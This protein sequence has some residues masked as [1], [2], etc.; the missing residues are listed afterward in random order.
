[1]T[2][3]R[4]IVLATTG[5]LGDLH[6]FLAIALGLKSRGHRVAVATCNYY[7]FR[8]ENLGLEFRPVAPHL[9][10][11]DPRVLELVTD[12][13]KGSENIFRE[14][15]MPWIKDSFADTGRA[16]EGADFVLSHPITLAVPLV[17]E[18]RNLPWASAVLAPISF[19]SK[20]EHLEF[21]GY[22]FVSWLSRTFPS[23]RPLL[24]KEGRRQSLAWVKPVV[25]L[26]EEVGLRTGSHPLFDGQHSPELVLALYSRLLGAPQ[27]DWPPSTTITGF[28]FHDRKDGRESLSPDLARFLESGPPPLVFTL[29]SSAVLA[30]G[31]F[32]AES[33]AVARSLGRRAVLLAGSNSVGDPGPDVCVADYAPYSLVFARAEAIICSGGVGTL[34]Q[35]LRSGTP[36]LVVPFGNDQPDNASRCLRLGVTR[37]LPRDRY[38]RRRAAD[39]L[40]AL[41]DDAGARAKA[42]E[43]A[44]VIAGENGVHS[45]CDAIERHL[46]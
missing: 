33:L 40:Q 5:S 31:E 21:S 29:G 35:V 19:F 6:P 34:S 42:R 7:R 23:L 18:Q 1:M 4:S 24:R 36:A 13:R 44:T 14:L 32:Y 30:P 12:E 25:A 20:H 26:R 28:C 27:P 22:P 10:P 38:Q 8:V 3:S 2:R 41:L 9:S 11:E 17:A 37:T 39:V 15:L 45:A 46:R 43:C 16:L